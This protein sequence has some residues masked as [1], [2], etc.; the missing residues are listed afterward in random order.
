[1]SAFVID[2]K[3]TWIR[4]QST[5]SVKIDDAAAVADWVLFRRRCAYLD[6][7]TTID[8]DVAHALKRRFCLAYLGTRAQTA[9]GM[10]VTPCASVFTAN[11]VERIARQNAQDRSAAY[12]WLAALMAQLVADEQS[13]AAP[14]QR[15]LLG[16]GRERQV[17]HLHLVPGH[18]H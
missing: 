9:G 14:R 4:R 7:T 10:Y 8:Q 15:N 3:P 2:G 5:V 17:P 18:P 13:Q 11:F 12:P 1:M 16:L 6:A